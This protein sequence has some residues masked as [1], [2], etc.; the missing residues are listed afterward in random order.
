MSTWNPYVQVI[1]KTTIQSAGQTAPAIGL[2]ANAEG[3]SSAIAPNTWVE[4]KGSNLAP[5]GDSRIWKAADFLN[6]EMPKQL[7]GVSVTVNGK[8]AYVYYISPSQV[9]I[10]TPPDAIPPAP[11]AGSTYE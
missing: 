8:A 6:N 7:D 9:N 1:M 10:L 2:V 3:E 5:A 11:G 4:I